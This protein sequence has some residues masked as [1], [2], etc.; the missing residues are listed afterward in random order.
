MKNSGWVG[1]G[2]TSSWFDAANWI[3][4]VPVAGRGALFSDGGTWA[5]SLAGTASAQAGATHVTG[6]NL[7]FSYGTLT[8]AAPQPNSGYANDLTI[9]SGGAVTIA[10]GAT[11]VSPNALTL[12]GTAS[13][14][15]DVFGTLDASLVQLSQSTLFARGHAAHVGISNIQTI[16]VNDSLLALQ[17]GATL[18]A[19][20]STLGTFY[21]SITVGGNQ[22]NGTVS[23]TGAGSSLTIGILY[24]GN[25]DNGILQVG[26]GGAAHVGVVYA[27]RGGDG[28]ITVSGTHSVLTAVNAVVIGD[29][30]VL[31]VGSALTI[32]H[33]GSVSAGTF[34]LDLNYGTLALDASASLAGT[35][36]SQVGRIEALS[37]GT[38]ASVVTLSNAVYLASNDGAQGQY[39]HTTSV[40]ALG[41]ATL[42]F[43]GVISGQN[44]AILS[45]GTGHI[46]LA[47]G[48]NS[49]HATSLF[50]ATLEI[51][52]TGAA[53]AGT[54]TFT[55]GA[56]DHPVLQLDHGVAFTNMI[57]GFAG[58]D[59]IDLRGFAFGSNIT[60]NF[61]AG[62]LTL[63]DG[64]QTASLALVGTYHSTE[65]M[66]AT[67]QH[68]G[69]LIELGHG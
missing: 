49:Y 53:G 37:S 59:A 26:N 40:S 2:H 69:T 12:G 29:V 33:G 6:D 67:D 32:T 60:D 8:L 42:A 68:G 4:G 44:D 25:G 30:N 27:G 35:I 36:V 39:D 17:A 55:G 16:D 54:L 51:A 66:F 45:A 52:A 31:P 13:G 46:V 61:A 28:M 20:P 5:I 56:T 64:S 41:H 7:T 11:L 9:D 1:R 58:H 63:T 43:T 23:V 22:T 50:N 47:N 14:T 18:D 34:G 19:G 15:L 62:T 3:G 21:S 24:L 48:A 38:A 57:A 65:F 10:R